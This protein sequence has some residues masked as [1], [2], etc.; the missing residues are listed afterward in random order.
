M[1]TNPRIRGRLVA[2]ALIGFSLT[3]PLGA[4]AA[5]EDDDSTTTTTIEIETSATTLATTTTVA[6]DTS[7]STTMAEA[8]DSVT[9]ETLP[10]TGN[11]SKASVPAAVSAL[12][13][14]A[15]LVTLGR[16]QRH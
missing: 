9:S 2:F 11:G 15:A 12:V 5:D 8:R 4:V 6:E 3:L 7:T 10:F 14:G 13:G 1:A 16:R